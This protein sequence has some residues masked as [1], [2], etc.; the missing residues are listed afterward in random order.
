MNE[1]VYFELNDW[2]EG[3]YYPA[4]EPFVGWMADAQS[5]PFNDKNWVHENELCVLM[6]VVGMSQNFCITAKKEWVEKMCPSLLNVHSKFL[7]EPNEEGKILGGFGHEFLEYTP[8]N[9]GVC[10]AGMF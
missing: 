4:E 5:I 7:C 2:M 6:D 1:I 9:I 8:E 3:T 10:Y